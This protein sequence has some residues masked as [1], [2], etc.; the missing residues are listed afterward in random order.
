MGVLCSRSNR[1]GKRLIFTIGAIPSAI[2]RIQD[3][4][5]SHKFLVSSDLDFIINEVMRHDRGG[6]AFCREV[7]FK[8]FPM[9]GQDTSVQRRASR[10]SKNACNGRRCGG[11]R[12]IAM[13]LATMGTLIFHV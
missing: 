3:Q 4:K 8:G 2:R 9:E 6:I 10:P 5:A 7:V 12:Q 11:G 13:Q 1:L